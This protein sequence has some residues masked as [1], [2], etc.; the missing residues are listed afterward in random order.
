[1]KLH[2]YW[3]SSSAYRV[4]IALSYKGIRYE[5]SATDLRAG[6]H[7][8]LSY[9]EKNPQGLL[10]MLEDGPVRLAQSLAIIEYLE[11]THPEP[12]LLPDAAVERAKVRAVALAIACEIQPLNNLRV[13]NHLRN[14]HQMQEQEV[15]SWY[16]TWIAEGFR[17]LEPQLK[18]SAGRYCFGDRVTLADVCLVPQ[19][20]N[21][22]RYNCDL[23]PFPTIRRIDSACGTLEAF[24][25][26]APERQPD[27]T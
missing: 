22:R 6:A 11:E 15:K 8:T 18:A 19:V 16:R 1:M 27:A 10:P 4:R 20:Y 3:R 13:L 5:Q 2:G 9:L 7:R 24:G 25:A 12:P 21:A 14:R 17:A 23:E 26:A